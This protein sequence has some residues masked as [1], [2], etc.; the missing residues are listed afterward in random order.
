MQSIM[1]PSGCGFPGMRR[2]WRAREVSAGRQPWR[3]HPSV[4]PQF[5]PREECRIKGL[6]IARNF[7][8]IRN[9]SKDFTQRKIQ[10]FVK[11]AWLAFSASAMSCLC[12]VI[13]QRPPWDCGMLL[14]LCTLSPAIVADRLGHTPAPGVVFSFLLLE[15]VTLTSIQD[16]F[17]SAAPLPCLFTPPRGTSS[18][19]CFFPRGGYNSGLS[20]SP[21]RSVGVPY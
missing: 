15:N 6:E 21:P 17:L 19:W 8:G 14:R 7:L 11:K 13:Q 10:I 9:H 12:R 16:C 18:I 20:P 1:T 2:L 4:K 5:F 3:G